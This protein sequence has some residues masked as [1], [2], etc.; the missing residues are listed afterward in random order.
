MSAS[1]SPKSAKAP[2]REELLQ[3]A[4]DAAKAG[5]K[6]GARIMFRQIL[7]EDK[8]NERAMMWMAKL[9]DSK[10][11]R[12]QWL[13]KVLTI[14]PDNTIAR[15]SL[16]RIRYTGAASENRTLII[17]GVVAAVLVVVLLVVFLLLATGA[18]G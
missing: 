4:I 6:E 11:E 14:N 15:Q 13:Q 2:N 8:R 9:A 1:R 12:T 17:F 3:M 10:T 5:Q 18:L 7:A 16:D